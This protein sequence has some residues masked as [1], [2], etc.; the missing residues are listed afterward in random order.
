MI[1]YVTNVVNT[2]AR[3]ILQRGIYCEG[4]KRKSCPYSWGRL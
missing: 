2:H 3:R 1:T 4:T